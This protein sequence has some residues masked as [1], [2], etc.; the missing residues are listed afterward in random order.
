MDGLTPTIKLTNMILT[1]TVLVLFQTNSEILAPGS[2][3]KLFR[4][5][6]LET[7]EMYTFFNLG[8]QIF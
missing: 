2:R 4:V 5:W 8:N 3:L 1:C 6:S 7:P